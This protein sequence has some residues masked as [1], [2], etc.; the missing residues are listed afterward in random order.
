MIR[1]VDELKSR[2]A[3]AEAELR[4]KY[5]GSDSKRWITLCSGT[6]CIASGAMGVKEQFDALIKEYGASDKVGVRTVGCFG[7]CSQGPFVRIYP[8]DTL[9][10]LVKPE[11]C[12]EIFEKD[13]LGGQIVERLL[14]KDP[15]TGEPVSKQDDIGFYA[16]QRKVA[17]HGVGIINPE[18]FDE[19]LGCGAFQGLIRALSMS[20]ADVVKEVLDSGLRGRGGG[21]FPTGRKWMFAMNGDGQKYVVCNGDEGDPG[22]FMDRSVLEDNPLSVIEGMMI[23]GY[24]IGATQG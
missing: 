12:R 5:D 19:A 13:I 24:A 1:T 22:A 17:L 14:Y 16:K 4:S 15:V 20:K 9:Y 2:I 11:D 23:A 6:G 18:I 21:G 7:L 8:E 10:V 3:K